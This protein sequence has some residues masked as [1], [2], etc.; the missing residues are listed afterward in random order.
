MSQVSSVINFALSVKFRGGLSKSGRPWR[1]LGFI[2][3]ALKRVGARVA[4]YLATPTIL[5]PVETKDERSTGF[6]FLSWRFNYCGLW[7][8]VHEGVDFYFV[9]NESYFCSWPLCLL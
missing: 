1:C 8:L 3:Q 4:S 9:D 5:S 6:R 2:I 7:H